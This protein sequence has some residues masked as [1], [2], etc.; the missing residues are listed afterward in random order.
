M[1]DRQSDPLQG[2]ASYLL[3]RAYHATRQLADRLLAEHGLTEL[4]HGMGPILFHL[5]EHDGCAQRDIVQRC[6]L[7]KA[8]VTNQVAAME[9]AGLVQRGRSRHDRRCVLVHLT[10]RGRALAQPS[11]RLL[12]D[13]ESRLRHPFDAERWQRFSDDLRELIRAAEQPG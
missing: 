12:V 5:F 1:N 13:L 10:E 3:G 7:D 11:R 4:T 2:F 6:G 8:T 9:R